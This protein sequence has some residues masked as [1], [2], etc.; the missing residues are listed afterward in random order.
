MLAALV[1]SSSPQLL[2]EYLQDRLYLMGSIPTSCDKRYFTKLESQEVDLSQFPAARDW[3]NRIQGCIMEQVEFPLRFWICEEA[4][5]ALYAKTKT[6]LTHFGIDCE[7]P[8]HCVL[9]WK[10]FLAKIKPINSHLI[11]SFAL[12][13]NEKYLKKRGLSD[14]KGFGIF[15]SARDG[16]IASG[17]A[18]IPLLCFDCEQRFSQWEDYFAK[19]VYI[20]VFDMLLS[21]VPEDSNSDLIAI[22]EEK[23]VLLLKEKISLLPDR[24]FQC[25]KFAISLLW[26]T[27]MLQTGDFQEIEKYRE[28]LLGGEPAAGLLSLVQIRCDFELFTN[29]NANF[30]HLD[31]GSCIIASRTQKG[32]NVAFL[33]IVSCT[34]LEHPWDSRTILPF[35]DEHSTLKPR[36]FWDSGIDLTSFFN[37]IPEM[38]IAFEQLVPAEVVYRDGKFSLVPRICHPYEVA[39]ESLL[40]SKPIEREKL[41]FGNCTFTFSQR[42]HRE[43]VVFDGCKPLLGPGTSFG[44]L[45]PDGVVFDNYKFSFP[46]NQYF[47]NVAKVLQ[48]DNGVYLFLESAMTHKVNR[49]TST[50]EG[51]RCWFLCMPTMLPRFY[52]C[53]S[54][55]ELGGGAIDWD[56]DMPKPILSKFGRSVGNV[57]ETGQG[58]IKFFKSFVLGDQG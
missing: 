58:M 41:V 38:K 31:L 43:Q 28:V 25:E 36:M 16:K 8:T 44:R 13:R 7:R 1:A 48:M 30:D 26:R 49:I 15:H 52:V 27:V 29:P 18:T 53:A 10:A 12:K 55:E 3:Y 6:S 32:A 50:K 9:C 33:G 4:R 34:I 24:D 56:R 21:K 22:Q 37:R 11:P 19:Q 51:V 40:S 2:E 57:L 54:F 17:K 47:E 23:E 14:V 46:S 39:L 20:P 45:V 5:Q 42:T 35:N